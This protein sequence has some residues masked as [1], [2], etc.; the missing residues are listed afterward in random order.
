M[1]SIH[2]RYLESDT[3]KPHQKNQPRV[4]IITVVRNMHDTIENAIKSVISQTYY[5][6]EYI[7][8]DG[9]SN[10]GTSEIIKK[11]KENIDVY[12]RESDESLYHAMNKGVYCS[13]GALLLFLNGDDHYMPHT[14][15]TLVRQKLATG[16]DVISGQAI[17]LNYKGEKI[18]KTTYMQYNST[19]K[20]GM[21]FRHELMLVPRYVYDKI[22][23][24]NTCYKIL[25]DW[26]F[27]KR[28]FD[29]GYRA[30]QTRIPLMYMR[31][32]GVSITEF[33]TR[34]SEV[35]K[36][37]KD[38]FPFLG[39]EILTEISDPRTW[40]REMCLKLIELY[41]GHWKFCQV[42]RDY[43][44]RRELMS[45]DD[46]CVHNEN[47]ILLSIVIPIYNA[48]STIKR[49]LES[50]LGT[51]RDDI[52]ILCIDDC[53]T[54][55]SLAVVERL[56]EADKRVLVINS[57]V[58]KG[59]SAA[60]NMGLRAAKGL[61]TFF[62]D[63]DDKV[64]IENVLRAVDT[65]LH[66][67]S[68][69]V[70]GAYTVEGLTGRQIR[71]KLP[72]GKEIINA[73]FSEIEQYFFH[74][75]YPKRAGP[76]TAGEGFWSVLYRT[77]QAKNIRFR[78]ELD[79]GEDSLFLIHYL[80]QAKR[81]SWVSGIFYRYYLSPNS[82]M[83]KM[84]AKRVL[85]AFQ[86][87]YW[88]GTI[89]KNNFSN[90]LAKFVCVQYWGVNFYKNLKEGG[91]K[92]G[93]LEII[94]SIISKIKA[95][96]GT[97][98]DIGMDEPKPIEIN[99]KNQNENEEESVRKDQSGK[100]TVNI[101]ST[102][103]KG[104][105]AI[106]SIRRK[107]ALRNLG[108]QANVI[109][110]LKTGGEPQTFEMLGLPDKRQNFVKEIIDKIWK[111][112]YCTATELFSNLG[113]IVSYDENRKYFEDA[114]VIHFHW[115]TGLI[116]ESNWGILKNKPFCWTVADMNP[117]T[118]GCHYS[119]GCREYKN[120]CENCQLLT[121]R[122]GI[123]E[124]QW[125]RKKKLY[126]QLGK[127][128]VICPSKWIADRARESSLFGDKEIIVIP[129]A[130]PIDKFIPVNQLV[131]RSKLNLPLGGKIILFGAD[132]VSNRRKGGDLLHAA[133]LL[134][135]EQNK[136]ADIHLATFGHYSLRAPFPV[137]NL[138]YLNTER[139]LSLAYSAADCYCLPSREDNA[140][141]TVAESMAC[142][143]P[144]VATPVG[145]VPDLVRHKETGFVCDSFTAE[146]LAEGIQ[147]VLSSLQKA[148]N[149]ALQSKIRQTACNHHN[150]TVAAERHLKVYQKICKPSQS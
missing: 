81:I 140:P 86:W 8:I 4:S 13:S 31:N 97:G 29:A 103:D 121:S 112:D 15:E 11:Y 10:D 43:G 93:E 47:T 32:T 123:A 33:D 18:G 67:N 115:V 46:V 98:P 1:N 92:D 149:I 125:V 23:G 148:G 119:E 26:D 143:T 122:K 85:D 139:E 38:E 114:D 64:E 59:V 69:A 72:G 45:S 7:I 55:G 75:Q 132:D 91:V 83:T 65:A 39:A 138:G 20:L 134:L 133:L 74:S 6:I 80:T 66:N 127:F 63:A 14:V 117:F 150:P 44:Y 5:N 35:R 71:S 49:T 79:Y 141:L 87:R 68:D 105:A 108:I 41:Q 36:I 19:I 22:G 16:V 99:R 111:S 37:L 27:S 17:D 3:T 106:G 118:G 30:S 146:G 104:G 78:E 130:L 21:V 147:F 102:T 73:R 51:T 110:G 131:A 135:S 126:D 70:I 88:A 24:Y 120:H 52:E 100:L 109:F 58:N 129:N 145:N 124:N 96:Y 62:L 12:L 57:E 28:L 48:K 113:G 101:F 89:L 142:G 76:R 90:D 144:V 84:S 9:C 136:D 60:R 40:S 82:A 116:D 107:R 56:A 137:T 34:V 50:I 95:E 54:D 42:V 53:S 2:S 61:Y 94:G 77:E 25:A 128:T